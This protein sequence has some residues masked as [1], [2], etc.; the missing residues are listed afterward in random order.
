MSWVR[1]DDRALSH[2]KFAGLVD[3]ERPFDLWV[4]SLTQ[5]QAFMTD[6]IILRESLPK[7]AVKAAAILVRRHLWDRH[8]LGW[9]IH[10]YLTWNDSRET[11]I[12]R[13]NG[14]KARKAAWAERVKNASGERVPNTTSERTTKPNQRRD[15]RD[16][17]HLSDEAHKKAPPDPRV[18]QFLVWFQTEYKTRRFGADYCVSWAKHGALVKEMLGATSF[19]RL[20]TLAK[21]LLSEKTDDDFILET[22]RGIEILKAK[23]NWL[24]DRLAAYEARQT[25]SR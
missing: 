7:G 2:P 5:A 17:E 1:I 22:D 3:L 13:I 4:W 23:F 10:D 18:K 21:I 15:Q 16:K 12:S 25:T 9:R 14:A 24:S 19:E 20:Q 6:G 11:I 8:Q